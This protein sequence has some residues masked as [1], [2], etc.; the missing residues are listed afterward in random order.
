MKELLPIILFMC[1]NSITPG[2]NNLMLMNS[3]LNFGIKRSLPHYFGICLGFSAMALIIALG[4][5]AIFLEYAWIKQILKILGAGYMLYLAWQIA[6]AALKVNANAVAKP[7]SFLQAVLFQWVNP[8]AWLMSI[9]AISI[10]SITANYLN[11]AIAIST[12]F[13]LIGLPCI[14]AWLL[15]GASLQKFLKQEKHRRWFNITMAICL[16]ASVAMIFFE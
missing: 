10:F 3:G 8:K 7:L 16:A 11:N 2:P 9:G 13:L 4:F 15:F 1:A 6:F 12:L 14:G 5:G